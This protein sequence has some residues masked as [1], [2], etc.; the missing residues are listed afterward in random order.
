MSRLLDR[1]Y[2][3]LRHPESFTT[4]SGL[5]KA[6]KG[7]IDSK[8]LNEWSE[9]QDTVTE[10]APARKNFVRRPTVAHERNAIWAMDT[11][12]FLQLEKF[13]KGFKYLVVAVDILTRYVYGVPLKSKKPSELVEGFT[14]LFKKS[15]PTYAVYVDAGGE[16]LSTFKRFLEQQGIQLWTSRNEV[17]SSI[18]ERYIQSFKHRLYRYLHYS[19]SKDWL[20][21][22]Q[23]ILDNMN[24]TYNNSIKMAPAECVSKEE[25]KEAFINLYGSRLGFT[26]KQ[27]DLQTGDQV[28]IS[29]LRHPFRK[30]YNAN[31]THLTYTLEKKFPKE[32]QSV[33]TLRANDDKDLVTGKFYR[34]ELK[35]AK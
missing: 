2:Y 16:Y 29:H 21:V 27:D 32:N 14:K 22:Y 31:F 8:T 15:K 5:K 11:A 33:Y 20:S 9:G 3:S 12:F 13:N 34:L 18:S 4:K 24:N 7:E 30:S 35:K 6:L 23:K 26:T 1:H 25:Q 19:K 17:K 10:Y 28:K